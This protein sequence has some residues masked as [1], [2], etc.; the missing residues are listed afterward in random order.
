[1]KLELVSLMALFRPFYNSANIF[2]TR[3]PIVSISKQKLK[4]EKLMEDNINHND[5]HI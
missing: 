3:M 1:M 5:V 2:S 4:C